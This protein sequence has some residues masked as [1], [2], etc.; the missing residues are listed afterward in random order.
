VLPP[1]ALFTVDSFP[2]N[3][4]EQNFLNNDDDYFFWP[5]LA[6]DFGFSFSLFSPLAAKKTR[7]LNK[8]LALPNPPILPDCPICQSA[9]SSMWRSVHPSQELKLPQ[10]TRLTRKGVRHTHIHFY[11]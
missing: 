1:S 2:L 10:L 4:I 6:T 9:L 8:L 3:Q 11:L 5:S 7:K